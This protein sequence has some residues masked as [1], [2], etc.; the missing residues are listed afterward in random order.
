M[1]FPKFIVRGHVEG[2]TPLLWDIKKRSW[3]FW[4]SDTQHRQMSLAEALQTVKTLNP[5]KEIVIQG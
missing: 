4:Y 1:T 3:L 5:G 2:A